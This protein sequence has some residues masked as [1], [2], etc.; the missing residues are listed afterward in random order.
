MLITPSQ[1]YADFGKTVR[2]SGV[3][4]ASLEFPTDARWQK[5]RNGNVPHNL[6]L[7]NEKYLG[8]DG[9]SPSL[10]VI[11]TVDFD[12][13]GDYRLQV[14]VS[15]GWCS[16]DTVSVPHVY[17]SKYITNRTGISSVPK[18]SMFVYITKTS[19]LLNATFSIDK[20][21]LLLF[22]KI[23]SLHDSRNIIFFSSFAV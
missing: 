7:N 1:Q 11:N 23:H 4:E 6:D 12:D 9:L 17:G 16:S 18:I 10:L 21:F 15:T 14:K 22:T 20:Y 8:S 5:I 3:I 19:V 2:F 13:A